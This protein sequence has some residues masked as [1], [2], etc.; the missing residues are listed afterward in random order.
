MRP[1][2]LLLALLAFSTPAANL[3]REQR[4]SEQLDA[5]ALEG[6]AVWLQAGALSFLALHRENRGERRL[7]AVILIHDRGAHAD[8]EAVISP[9]R[10]H[11]AD[12]GWETLS[13]Q[14]PVE[15]GNP[16]SPATLPDDAAPRIRAAVDYLRGRQAEFLVLVGH[17]E[18]A[19][20]ALAYLG[21]EPPAAV[22]GLVAIGLPAPPGAY[23]DTVIAAVG[24]L[25]LPMLDLYGSQDL[26]A[27]MASA[28]ARQG[29]ARRNGRKGYRQERVMGADHDFNGL[30]Q[31]LEQ[32]VGAWLRRLTERP[33]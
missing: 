25:D 3:S 20:R 30:Q 28:P 7:G 5:H 9:L 6:E 18:G 11:L 23:G 16:V 12:I 17:G 4:L 13:L 32:R 1:I 15:E 14:M 29:A 2:I 10:H 19:L 22:R 21:I 27:V 26:P 8:W 31:G 33:G 24:G